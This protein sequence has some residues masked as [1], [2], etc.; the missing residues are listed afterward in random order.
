MGI[1]DQI[2]RRRQKVTPVGT[3]L[4]S[5]RDDGRSLERKSAVARASIFLV[6]I[7]TAVLAFPT[8]S[9]LDL[10]VNL[11]EQWI[12]QNV[13][14]EFDFAILKSEEELQSQRSQVR[15]RT[16]PLFSRIPNALN[17]MR[18][19]RDS[20]RSQMDRVYSVYR[21]S[22]VDSAGVRELSPELAALQQSARVKLTPVQWTRLFDYFSRGIRLDRSLLT[23]TYRISRELVGQGVMDIPRDSVLTERIIIRDE[24]NNTDVEVNKDGLVGLNEAYNSVSGELNNAYTS[25]EAVLGIAIF[26]S[27]FQPSLRYLRSETE[28]N[29]Q[30]REAGISPSEGVVR[31]GDV[32]VSQGDLV[33]SDILNKLRSYEVARTLRKGQQIVW[34]R[35]LGKIVLCASIYFFFFLYLYLLR[36]QIFDDTKMVFLIAVVFAAMVGLFAFALR[37]DF[38]GLY[39]IPIA[40][41]SILLTIIFDSRVA[42]FATLTLALL[43]GLMLQMDYEY[44]LATII[45]SALGIYSVRDIKNR[46]QF[47][48]SAGLVLI[49]YLVVLGGF[50]LFK[51]APPERM[52]SVVIQVGLHSFLLVLAYPLLWV[53]ERLFGIT[54]DLTLLELSDTNL[55][56]L[57]ELSINAPGTFNHTLQVANLAEAAADRIGANALLTRV[58]ALYHD[59]GKMPKPEYFVENQRPGENPHDQLKPRMSALIIINHVKEGLEMG[60]KYGLPDRVLKFIPMHHGNTLVEYFHRQALAESP[61][62]ENVSESEFRYPGPTPDS[63]E[64]GILML[65]DSVEAASR[66]LASPTHKRLDNLI[67]DIFDARIESGQLNA[68]NLNFRELSDIK[69]TFLNMLVGMYHVRIKYPG[70]DGEEAVTDEKDVANAGLADQ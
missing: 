62:E 70:K 46:S 49:G 29:W 25:G 66:S 44:V 59:I 21:N 14:A 45:A 17:T 13:V 31:S 30:A 55:P 18:V 39:V 2:L 52:L 60:K 57:K 65:A 36:P 50:M 40:I 5:G 48:I 42:L 26:S 33:T 1:R 22:P 53:F 4:E 67:Q 58:G 10:R 63:K 15:Q 23:D 68:T 37:V 3:T 12:K 11:G 69:E 54:T 20:V 32:I 7:A 24:L 38:V 35:L 47:F 27:F 51:N 41:A 61:E 43:G 34:K 19:G 8:Q 56:L 6:L 28:A 64:T 16:P 9:L